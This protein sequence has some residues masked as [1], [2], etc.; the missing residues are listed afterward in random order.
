[1]GREVASFLPGEMH[2]T[3]TVSGGRSLVVRVEA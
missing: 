2:P 1:M 3:S